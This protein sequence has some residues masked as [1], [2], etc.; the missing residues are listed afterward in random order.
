MWTFTINFLYMVTNIFFLCFSEPTDS[1][2]LAHL[3][4]RIFIDFPTK[5]RTK[6]FVYIQSSIQPV[7]RSFPS[8]YFCVATWRTCDDHFNRTPPT[9]RQT[10][11]LFEGTA[12]IWTIRRIRRPGGAYFV[13]SKYT[14]MGRADAATGP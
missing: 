2:A 11:N 4:S 7:F 6:P 9:R 3:T 12:G 5:H 10:M 8:Y 14:T 13:S 1:S